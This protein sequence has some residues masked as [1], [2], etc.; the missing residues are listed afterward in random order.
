[1]NLFI[2]EHLTSGANAAEALPDSLLSEGDSMVQAVIRDLAATGD[3][4][5]LTL[6]DQ[7]LNDLPVNNCETYW[8][9]DQTSY[10]KGWQKC[11]EAADAALLI[12]PESDAILPR[13]QEAVTATGRTELGC[14][15]A[16]TRLCGD[17]LALA[18]ALHQQG[19]PTLPS[20]SLTDYHHQPHFHAQQLVIKPRDG[21]GCVD[22]FL[23]DGNTD[24]TGWLEDS[25]S[26]WLVQPYLEGT[27]ISLNA[28][29]NDN[30]AM[31]LSRNHQ[32]LRLQQHQLEVTASIPASDG[33][34][35]ITEYNARQLLLDLKNTLPGLWGFVG[36]DLIDSAD[37]PV[38]VE[39]N[40]RVTSSYP[41]ISATTGLNPCRLLSQ[42]LHEKF[43]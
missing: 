17:K 27:A 25:P 8:V 15:P 37:G 16:V 22:T 34:S 11:L 6:R 10:E 36:I 19:I 21:A 3:F 14:A 40:P 24:L 33:E 23:L 38:V 32:H 42:H 29:F 39:I 30:N 28:F 20:Q 12:A 13:L 18:A 26:R 5:L 4:Q 43:N 31:L 2:Y 7:T 35:I 1:M 9:N 41:A